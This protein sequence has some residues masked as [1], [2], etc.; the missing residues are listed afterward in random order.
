MKVVHSQERGR[1]ANLQEKPQSTLG[2]I[3]D[4]NN[5]RSFISNSLVLQFELD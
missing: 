3:L 1:E 5:T 4:S 2:I